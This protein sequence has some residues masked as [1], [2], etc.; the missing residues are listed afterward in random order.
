[1]PFSSVCIDVLEQGTSTLCLLGYD[2]QWNSRNSTDLVQ[3]VESLVQKRIKVPLQRLGEEVDSL[4][5]QVTSLKEESAN[6]CSSVSRLQIALKQLT[7][8]GESS[9]ERL[10]D[11]ARLSAVEDSLHSLELSRRSWTKEMV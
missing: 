3:L 2:V 6:C 7:A 5:D 1:M 8:A 4:G 11:A 9:E 10:K